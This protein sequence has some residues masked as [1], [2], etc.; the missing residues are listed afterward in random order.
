M[1]KLHFFI[2]ELTG[3]LP[4]MA[5]LLSGQGLVFLL[6]CN[7]RLIS[8]WHVIKKKRAGRGR[9]FMINC[10]FFYEE[11][12]IGRTIYCHTPVGC[13]LQQLHPGAVQPP[14]NWEL[15]TYRTIKA[16]DKRRGFCPWP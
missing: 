8:A 4:A 5:R 10:A 12:G 6:S 16:M 9:Y 13:G 14:V 1:S 3:L 15:P 7:I 2:M 11:S